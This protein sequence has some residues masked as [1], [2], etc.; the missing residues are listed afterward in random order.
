MSQKKSTISRRNFLK[1]GTLGAGVLGTGL[2]LGANATKA[3]AKT[4]D[5]IDDLFTYTD[6]FEPYDKIRTAFDRAEILY[7]DPNFKLQEGDSK[8][9]FEQFA[10]INKN[11]PFEYGVTPGYTDPDQALRKGAMAIQHAFGHEATGA[12]EIFKVDSD[13]KVIPVGLHSQ[14]PAGY[15]NGANK[16]FE[17]KEK[18]YEFD[19]P[20]D[21]TY[22]VKKAMMKYGASL[23]GIA[24]YDE[25]M[26]Y[27]TSVFNPKGDKE[28]VAEIRNLYASNAFSFEPKSVIVYA[29]EMDY[30]LYKYSPSLIGGTADSTG[31]GNAAVTGL[32]G[33]RFLR[34]LGYNTRHSV[35]DV[36]PNIPHAIAAG[37]GEP[38][39]M[40][41]LVSE[42]FGPRMRL[43]KI[44]TDLEL[45]A[46]K[47]KT[48]GV[49]QF[50][51]VCMV[52]ADA[53]PSAAINYC[54][55]TDDPDNHPYSICE[56]GGVEGKWYV[57]GQKC[58]ANWNFHVGGMCGI[59]ITVCPY[60]KPQT[61]NHELVKMVTLIPGLNSMA[62]YFDHF[63]GFGTIATEQEILDFWDR[64]V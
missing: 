5:T 9:L 44:F 13:G 36:G 27:S 23:V 64:T 37:L 16:F 10:G 39:R 26:V 8:L 20:E 63:F 50:C 33:A 3:E 49:R 62:R 11:V 48:F 15:P 28:K 41:L 22:A 51:E 54:K 52:C 21:A 4:Y 6:E 35:N 31:Y 14:T 47:P 38:T 42:E 61:W 7:L 40:G 24:P 60:N 45:V 46:D 55:T 25:R 12:N 18:R 34:E 19:S 56:Q 17:V 58:L 1:V 29:I 43:G 32:R 53:C 30:E 59:C 2:F 57:D